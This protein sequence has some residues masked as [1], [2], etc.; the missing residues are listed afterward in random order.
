[1]L[2]DNEYVN[3]ARYDPDHTD[4][5]YMMSR[6]T[7]QITDIAE[8]DTENL[9]P[10]PISLMLLRFQTMSNFTTIL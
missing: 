10:I 8:S 6:N 3:M 5:A 1:M 2:L 7:Q 9:W 4:V